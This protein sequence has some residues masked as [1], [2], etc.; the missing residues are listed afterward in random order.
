A[1]W[2]STFT[3]NKVNEVRFAWGRDFEF[4]TTNSGGPSASLLN[5]ASYGETSA[6]P[7]PAFPDEHRIQISDNFSW[8]KGTHFVKMG[9]DVNLIHEL[10]VNLFQGDGNYSYNST[11][12]IAGCP[13]GGANATFCRWLIDAVGS[14]VGDGLTGKHWASFT[15]VNDPITHTGKD[16]FYN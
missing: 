9:A 10:L 2:N 3:S 14:D 4:D 15:Q 6:L 13:G 12:A 7:R 5:I 11:T 8:V 16:D 1:N